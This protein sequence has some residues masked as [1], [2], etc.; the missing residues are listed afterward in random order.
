M[1]DTAFVEKLDPRKEET[2]PLAGFG[3]FNF[4]R[5]QCREV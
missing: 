3:F 5:N 1:D 2:E 4:Y